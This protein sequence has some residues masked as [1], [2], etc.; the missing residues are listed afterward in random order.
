MKAKSSRLYYGWVIVASFFV[1]N[2]V[3][4]ASGTL[5]FG[6]FVIPMAE[7]LGL[8]RQGIGWAQTMRLWASGFSGILIGRWLDRHGPRGPML[9]AI[10]VTTSGLLLLSRAQSPIVLLGVLLGLGITGWTAPAGG[11][12]IATVPVSKWFIRL[13]GR[14]VGIVQLGLG[15]GAALLVPISQALISNRGWRSA[16]VTLSWLSALALPLV[17]LMRRQ[18]SDMGL[19][20]DGET[21]ISDQKNWNT[22]L[23][24]SSRSSPWTIR[25]AVRTSSMWKLGGS[26]AIMAFLLGAASVHRIPHWIELGFH[27]STVS[28]AVSLDAVGATIMALTAGFVVERLDARIVGTASCISFCFAVALMAV[29]QAWTPLLFGSTFLFGI[30]VGLYMV[31]GGVIWAQ[32]YGWQ[33]VG[34]IRGTILPFT[35]LAG[36]LGAPL[37]GAMRDASGNYQSSWLLIL[38]LCVAATILIVSARSPNTSLDNQR[39]NS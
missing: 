17:F 34:T 19:N 14:A 38:A 36:G 2:I 28:L 26:L 18:P 5:N 13:R 6:F 21:A 24:E 39:E 25:E 11:A 15:I 23:S 29:G 27:P 33:F 31:V 12:L 37:T 7:E 1:F 32:Y 35:F 10:V 22:K 20:P 9:L 4:Q 30:G 8:S 3:G 16:W